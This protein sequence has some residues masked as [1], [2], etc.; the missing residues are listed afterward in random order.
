MAQ[1]TGSTAESAIRTLAE[2][3]DGN[4][5]SI[6]IVVS[7]FNTLITERLLAGALEALAECGVADSAFVV[8]WVPGSFELP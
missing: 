7:R 8:A 5:L 3:F 6:G 4:G 2:D 1:E